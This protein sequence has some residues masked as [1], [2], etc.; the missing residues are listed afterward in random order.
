[1][2]LTRSH[3]PTSQPP[4]T[5]FAFHRAAVPPT[6]PTHALRPSRLPGEPLSKKAQ[7]AE[8]IAEFRMELTAARQLCYLAAVAAA[9]RLEW[10]AADTPRSQSLFV[11]TLAVGAVG[12]LDGPPTSLLAAAVARPRHT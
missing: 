10:Q 9:P 1:M 11:Q 5:C 2:I 6:N 4:L 7:I 8:R 3:L 12:A